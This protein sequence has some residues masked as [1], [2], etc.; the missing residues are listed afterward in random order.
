MTTIKNTN[1][2]VSGSYEENFA[3]IFGDKPPQRGSFIQGKDGKL[4]PRETYQRE[5]VNS[6]MIMKPLESFVS[7]IDGQVISCRSQL[8]AHNKKHGVTN[9]ADYSGGYIEQRARERN[10]AG[11]RYLKESRVIDIHKAIQKHS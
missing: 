5:R 3:K 11:E 4:V 2:A 1:Q 6:P 8:A 10:A 7:P 9:S